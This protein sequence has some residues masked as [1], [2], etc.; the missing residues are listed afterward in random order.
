MRVKGIW[1]QALNKFWR[2]EK[3]TTPCNYVNSK[4]MFCNLPI[5]PQN[6]C[7]KV[8]IGDLAGEEK[9]SEC[10]VPGKASC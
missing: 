8:P 4:L 9:K 2:A 5:S 10:L 6:R 1:P 3:K 7:S